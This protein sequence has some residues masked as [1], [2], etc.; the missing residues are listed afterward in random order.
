MKMIRFLSLLLAGTL[1]LA[2][3]ACGGSAK[4]DPGTS[5]Q[6]S[7]SDENWTPKENVTMIVSY[8][9]GS[10][11]DNTARV[12]AA[13]AEKYIGKPVIIENLEGG[14]GSIGWTALSQAAPDGYTLGFINLP[15][16]NATISEGLATYTVDSFAPICNHVTETSVVLVK[17][18][19]QFN[20]L[21][22]LVKFAKDNPGKLKASTNGNRAS[23]HIGAQVLATSAGFEYTDIPYGGTADQLLALRQGEVDFS[24]AKV[25][26]F[27]S[28]TSEVKV[29]A[30]YNQERLAG[31][32]DVPTMGELGYYDQWLGSSRCI[33]APAGTPEN[34]IKFYEDAFQK[35]MEDAD[36]V[37]VGFRVHVLGP[38]VGRVKQNEAPWASC[39]GNYILVVTM[40]NDCI[41]NA[42]VGA[43]QT[44]QSLRHI[45]PGDSEGLAG[46]GKAVDLILEEGS[47]ILDVFPA[48]VIEDLGCLNDIVK[49]VGDALEPILVLLERKFTVNG[50]VQPA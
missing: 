16:F 8:K 43:H 44:R 48:G 12:L 49:D 18:D 30:V 10:G 1:A 36:Y 31:Y 32:P 22:D 42:V 40:Q 41:S 6:P 13:Y 34:V 2:L 29:L 50:E 28:F 35:L 47:R 7:T 4:T 3:T 14:S 26:D 15:N 27:A 37:E 5:D 38:F 20:T 33:V 45:P 46:G 39:V 25:A 24:V 9:A 23:N 21:E 19:S 11:T 17:A